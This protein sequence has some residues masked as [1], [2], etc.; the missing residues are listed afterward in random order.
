MIKS[1]KEYTWVCKYC[2]KIFRV[3]KDLQQHYKEYPEHRC[4]HS[5]KQK[6]EYC[7]DYCNKKWITTKEGYKNHTAHCHSNPNGKLGCWTNKHHTE[8]SKNKISNSMKKAH[9]EGRAWNI[10]KSRW[11]NKMSYPEEF[12][13]LVIKN[14]FSDKNYKHEYALG[15]YSLDFAWPHKK[16]CIEIDGDQHQRFQEII[17]RDERKNNLIKNKGWQ[18]LRIKWKDMFHDTKTWIKIAKDFIDN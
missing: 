14:E 6:K 3:R 9:Q 1:I 15:I 4:D 18:V 11:N 8:E 10:G 16:K 2:G 13:S 17:E 5:N 12:F 7:C